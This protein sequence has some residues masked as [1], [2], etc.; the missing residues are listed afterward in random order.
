MNKLHQKHNWYIKHYLAA[1]GAATQT[2]QLKSVI[3]HKKSKDFS[4]EIES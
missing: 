1:F 4:K 2:N 3:P